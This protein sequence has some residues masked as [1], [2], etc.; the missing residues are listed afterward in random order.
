MKAL[1]SSF[2]PFHSSVAFH[3]ETSPLICCASQMTGSYM[4][5]NTGLIREDHHIKQ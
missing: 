2:N 4:K 1:I 5:C 3:I